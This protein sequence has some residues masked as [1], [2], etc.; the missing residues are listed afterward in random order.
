MMKGRLF[1]LLSL[2]L[3][4]ASAAF[5][6]AP[7]QLKFSRVVDPTLP[8]ETNMAGIPG[9]KI[10]A[11]NPSQVAIIAAMTEAQ[12]EMLRAEGMTLGNTVEINGRS[13]ISIL[14]ISAA[15]GGEL[16]HF[17]KGHSGYR[18][19]ARARSHSRHLHRLDRQDVG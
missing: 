14:S 16:V 15:Q 10:Y 19:G 18:R 5:A 11:D 8:I 2:A 13:M 6:Q 4:T 1:F 12:K 3:G 9:L 17:R 7:V